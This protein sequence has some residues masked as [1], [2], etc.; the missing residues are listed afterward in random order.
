MASEEKEGPVLASCANGDCPTVLDFDLSTLESCEA[1][2]AAHRRCTVE[3][4]EPLDSLYR[5]FA[6]RCLLVK[7]LLSEEESLFLLEGLSQRSDLEPL[8]Y[9]EDYRRCSR[10]VVSS[11]QL[12]RL[13]MARLAPIIEKEIGGVTIGPGDCSLQRPL[14]A[15]ALAAPRELQMGYGFDG[16]WRPLELNEC[17]RFCRYEEGG[18]F[19]AHCDAGYRRTEE[20]Q[21]FYTCMHYLD[22]AQ[23]GGATRFL[24]LDYGGTFESLMT[25]Q[26][27]SAVLAK[28]HPEPGMCILFWHKGFPHEGEDVKG[29]PKHILRT[30]LIFRREPESRPPR[31]SQQELALKTLREAQA[32]EERKEL[33]RA[34]QLYRRAFKLDP[35]LEKMV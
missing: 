26:P 24:P 7:G 8:K 23:E 32:A 9:R 4:V 21:S 12:A 19:R 17:F 22:R 33:D 15:A 30:D 35:D 16:D 29:G 2:E 27:E 20:E 1:L 14:G 6:A 25:L 31:T 10:A 18:F 28:V 3:P 34:C 13:L 11:S 5:P